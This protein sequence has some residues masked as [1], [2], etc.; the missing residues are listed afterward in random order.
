MPEGRPSGAGRLR[1][2]LFNGDK[3][4]RAEIAW[5][6]PAGSRRAR[7]QGQFLHALSCD[8]ELA[9]LHSM[10]QAHVRDVARVLCRHASW[11]DRTTRPT[12]AR[13]AEAVDVGLTTWKKCRRWLEDHGYLGTVRKGRMARFRRVLAAVLDNDRN[14]AA[15]YVLAVPAKSGQLTRNAGLPGREARPPTS[16][17]SEPGT[18]HTREASGTPGN[19]TALRADSPATPAVPLALRQGRVLEKLS[20][21]AVSHFWRP[22]AAA[23]WTPADFRHAIDHLPGGAPHRRGLHDVIYPAGWLRW[24]LAHWLSGDGT[25]V[26]SRSQRWAAGNARILAEREQRRAE[27]ARLAAAAVPPGS[28]FDQL[29]AEREWRRA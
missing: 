6:I 24:R 12:R 4:S 29:R 2:A 28:H 19:R 20:E 7:S 21:R 13:I 23:S 5:A 11:E 15:V 1:A 3:I 26:A 9:G 17:R 8:P 25:P 10:F 18:T 16:S 27:L 14:D 22:F